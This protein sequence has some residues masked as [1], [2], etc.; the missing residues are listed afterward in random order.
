MIPCSSFALPTRD[1]IA[2][3]SLCGAIAS[4]RDGAPPD[5]GALVDVLVGANGNEDVLPI[6]DQRPSNYETTRA[7]P[8]EFFSRNDARP[9]FPETRPIA[10]AMSIHDLEPCPV[11]KPTSAEWTR[12]ERHRVLK[13]INSTRG[14]RPKDR[15]QLENLVRRPCSYPTTSERSLLTLHSLYPQTRRMFKNGRRNGKYIHVSSALLEQ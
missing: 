5:A 14:R 12:D 7:K 6:W 1:P 3:A 8:Q 15:S 9:R 13:D 2:W 10:L 11:T 4:A